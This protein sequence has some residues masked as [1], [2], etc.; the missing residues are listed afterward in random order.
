MPCSIC[1]RKFAEDRVAK[2][3]VGPDDSGDDEDHYDDDERG[4]LVGVMVMINT[5]LTYKAGLDNDVDDGEVMRRMTTMERVMMRRTK[6]RRTR[7][8]NQ[9]SSSKSQPTTGSKGFLRLTMII[10]AS[11]DLR[12]DLSKGR[13]AF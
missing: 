2:H 5:M 13:E 3:K 10:L 4:Q 11:G 12:K 1:G 8:D 7:R 9:S 6:L